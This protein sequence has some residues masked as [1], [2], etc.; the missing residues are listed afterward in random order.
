MPATNEVFRY[1]YFEGEKL[2]LGH[3]LFIREIF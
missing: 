1:L 3:F 2:P